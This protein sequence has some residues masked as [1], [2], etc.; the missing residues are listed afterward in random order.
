MR[1]AWFPLV[2]RAAGRTVLA[3]LLDEPLLDALGFAHPAPRERRAVEGAIRARS[4]VVRLLPSR[5]RPR[6]R[7]LERQRSYPD[8]YEIERLGPGEGEGPAGPVPP[9]TALRCRGSAP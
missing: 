6:L 1:L 9:R 8:G 5:R 2:P 3:A 7:T 4:R